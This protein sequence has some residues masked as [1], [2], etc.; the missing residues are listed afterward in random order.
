M[1]RALMDDDR[2]GREN[3]CP[4]RKIVQ[5]GERRYEVRGVEKRFFH[6]GRQLT[7]LKPIDLVIERGEMLSIASH[8][9]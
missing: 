8:S 2:R 7:V 9:Q 6:E 5:Y 3:L 4:L 1:E